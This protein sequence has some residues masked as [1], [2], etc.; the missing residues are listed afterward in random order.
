M[1]QP[2]RRCRAESN[3]WKLR[4]STRLLSGLGAL[5]VLFGVLPS[6]A[7]ALPPV[8][9]HN[10]TV[11]LGVG[12]GKADVELNPTDYQ[13]GWTRGASAEYRIGRLIGPHF[14][15]AVGNR[16]W[17]DEGGIEELK[18][19]ASIQNLDLMLT[20]YPGKTSNWTSGFYVS[21]GA[22]R[23]HARLT[24]LEPIPGGPNQYGETYEIV[25]KEDENGFS[26]SAGFGYEFRI[27]T[28]FTAGAGFSYNFLD[29]QDEA[30]FN[31]AKFYPGG[32]TLH[33]Y[34]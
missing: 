21:G 6:P 13:T 17:L 15:V 33:W 3:S 19:R 5:F 26:W 18:I 22:G 10:W 23:A 32:V 12:T 25:A 1:F 11:A 16:Q 30:I 2:R 20:V 31:Q 7:R 9:R 27:S 28:H 8:E 34:F 4:L 29:F 14:M 24:A